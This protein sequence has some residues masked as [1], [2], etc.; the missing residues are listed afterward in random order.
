MIIGVA[1]RNEEII[2]MLPKPNRHCHCFWHLKKM[3][4]NAAKAKIG[5]KADDQGF[6]THTGKYLTREQACKYAKRIK[7]KTID[8]PVKNYLF[9]EDL[10]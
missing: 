10:W 4:I 3:G 1:L 8:G 5:V 9:S 6:Y 2:I 7:Q